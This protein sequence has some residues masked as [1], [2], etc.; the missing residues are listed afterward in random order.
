MSLIDITQDGN[1]FWVIG[2]PDLPP[3][4]RGPVI[5]GVLAFWPTRAGDKSTIRGIVAYYRE[6]LAAYWREDPDW[7]C[8]AQAVIP[9]VAFMTDAQMRKIL[10]Q[11]R[12][13]IHRHMGA[14]HVAIAFLRELERGSRHRNPAVGTEIA[15]VLANEDERHSVLAGL[16]EHPPNRF[17]TDRVNFGSRIWSASRPVLHLAVALALV[18]EDWSRGLDH[19]PPEFSERF[20]RDV[21]RR[22]G[23][24][25]PQINA[26]HIMDFPEIQDDILSEAERLEA[27]VVQ[28]PDHSP[29]RRGIV[30]L[31]LSRRPQLVLAK[32][33][34]QPSG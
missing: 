8:R 4:A 5:F 9:D 2:S 30:R 26:D 31:R 3:E 10:S 27:L 21:N 22:D 29:A 13:I 7:A 18:V 20:P 15:R 32:E 17:E 23:R 19:L 28:L 6:A 1:D 11:G 14:A 12:R 16:G 24:I 25:A 34:A 33:P